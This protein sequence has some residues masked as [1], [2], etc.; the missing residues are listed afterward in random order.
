MGEVLILIIIALAWGFKAAVANEE[1][2]VNDRETGSVSASPDELI[3]KAK[4]TVEDLDALRGQ[5]EKKRPSPTEIKA[6]HKQ[7]RA[8]EWERNEQRHA[9][10]RAH[11]EKR[12][13]LARK[14]QADSGEVHSVHMDSCE[15]RLES[16]KVLY[17]AGI[18]D[19]EEYAQRVALVHAKRRHFAALFLR[20]STPVLL[21]DHRGLQDEHDDNDDEH[22][23]SHILRSFLLQTVQYLL[24]LFLILLFRNEPTVVKG[25]QF[26]EP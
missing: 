17:D 20:R 21:G 22:Q 3:K 2:K 25:L 26:R 4:R 12:W 16:L 7:H 19:R 1:K 15:D 8:D 10:E 9:D 5:T 13:E 6:L 24:A 23:S 11:S 14:K 18:L